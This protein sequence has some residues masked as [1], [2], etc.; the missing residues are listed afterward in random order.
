ML[1]SEGKLLCGACPGQARCLFNPVGRV[2][3]TGP[4]DDE[5]EEIEKEI[6]FEHCPEMISEEMPKSENE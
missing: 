1:S 5:V 2:T 4:G 3:K 6:Y